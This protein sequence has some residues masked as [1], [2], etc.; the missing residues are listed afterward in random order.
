MSESKHFWHRRIRKLHISNARSEDGNLPN[1]QLTL[2]SLR[3]L[4]DVRQSEKITTGLLQ[5]GI[6]HRE[7]GPCG[8]APLTS[9]PLKTKRILWCREGESNPQG[10]KYRRILSPLRLPVPP[11]RLWVEMV[12]R[13]YQF[14]V[15]RSR[16][17]G[18]IFYFETQIVPGAYVKA[19]TCA[20][21][22]SSGLLLDRDLA[23]QV[24]SSRVKA[25]GGNSTGLVLLHG[26]S[27]LQ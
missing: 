1:H 7:R 15:C 8:G 6:F 3:L 27:R 2:R 14:N 11:S 16:K 18:L 12:N 23:T 4:N 9:R 21:R 19:M 10:T 20:G 5:R 13:L 24:L 22:V 25:L 17:L 26:G